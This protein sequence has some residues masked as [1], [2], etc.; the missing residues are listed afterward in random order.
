MRKIF[1]QLLITMSVL[2]AVLYQSQWA[3]AD[4]GGNNRCSNMM[5][6]CKRYC[7]IGYSSPT[8]IVQFESCTRECEPTYHA[9]LKCDQIAENC[10]GECRS[11]E[12]LCL[13]NL[14]PF[15]ELKD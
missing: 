10:K 5:D 6:A 12:V 2:S 8:Q 7:H 15:P 4:S 11:E 3:L 13:N 14:P 1:F 9:C